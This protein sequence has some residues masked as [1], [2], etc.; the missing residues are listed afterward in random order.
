MPILCCALTATKL[1]TGEGRPAFIHPCVRPHFATNLGTRATLH[2]YHLEGEKV[3]AD[4]RG[5]K[6]KK[7]GSR[8]ILLNLAAVNL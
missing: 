6:S 4:P 2:D 1:G 3:N 5:F 8:G 7:T